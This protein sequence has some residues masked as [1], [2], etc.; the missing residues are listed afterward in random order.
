MNKNIL[1]DT[2]I[3]NA[4]KNKVLL[5]NISTENEDKKKKSDVFSE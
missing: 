1:S 5:N 2:I 3:K 4:C